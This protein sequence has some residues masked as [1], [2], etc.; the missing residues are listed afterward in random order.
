MEEKRLWFR[1]KNYGYGWYPVTWEGWLC[2]LIYLVVV[3]LA[4]FIGFYLFP[5]TYGWAIYF[6][7]ITFSTILLIFVSYKKGEK[8][9]FR[10]GKK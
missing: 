9:T 7:T 2:I 1:A 6:T 8:A 4:A 3:L 10:W 5:D